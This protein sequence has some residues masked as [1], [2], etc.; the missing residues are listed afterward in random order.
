MEVNDFV[1]NLFWGG[2][3]NMIGTDGHTNDG[4]DVPGAHDSVKVKDCP[5]C[6]GRWDEEAETFA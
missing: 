3:T 4:L 5:A 1:S 2:G 6:H